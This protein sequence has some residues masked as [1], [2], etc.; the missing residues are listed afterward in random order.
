MT[1]TTA[2]KELKEEAL[3]SVEEELKIANEW[4]SLDQEVWDKAK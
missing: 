1:T 2:K 4:F 3:A